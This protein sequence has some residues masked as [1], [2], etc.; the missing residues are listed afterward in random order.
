M[1]FL[2]LSISLI[3]RDLNKQYHHGRKATGWATGFLAD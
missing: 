2:L 1:K 3:L